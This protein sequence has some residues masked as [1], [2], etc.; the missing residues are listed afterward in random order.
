M[1]PPN[2]QTAEGYHAVHKDLGYVSGRF[3]WKTQSPNNHHGG[4][5]ELPPD[6]RDSVWDRRDAAFKLDL[7]NG[8]Y[9]VTNFFCSAEDKGHQVNLL[10][11]GKRMIKKLIIPAG[12]EAVKHSYEIEVTDEHLTQVIYRPNRRVPK[13]GMHNHWVWNGFAVEQIFK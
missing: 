9:R 11:N 7:P 2:G 1:Q 12:N 5:A 13:A 3:G 10:V 6:Y 4:T 8:N